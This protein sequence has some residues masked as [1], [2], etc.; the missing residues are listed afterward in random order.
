MTEQDEQQQRPP[1]EMLRYIEA[2]AEEHEA[3]LGLLQVVRDKLVRIQ[4]RCDRIEKRPWRYVKVGERPSA[5]EAR[6]LTE[7]SMEWAE[8]CMNTCRDFVAKHT[9]K[10]EENPQ[11]GRE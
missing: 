5:L 9:P 4:E 8:K 10:E 2:E 3:I 6:K 1:I 7:T 11:Q